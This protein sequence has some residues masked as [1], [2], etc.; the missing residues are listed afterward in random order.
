MTLSLSAIALWPRLS[1]RSLHIVFGC[2][3]VALAVAAP[4]RAVAEHAV[5]L[6]GAPK[7]PASFQHFDYVNPAAPS[8]GALTLSVVSENSSFDKFNPFSLRGK[9]APGLSELV[10]ETL[11]VLS[12]DE[13]NTQYGLLADDIRV[14]ADFGSVEFHLHPGARFSDGQPVTAE[15]V[16][17]SFDVLTSKLASPRFRA[18]FDEVSR[19]IVL[20]AST[21]RFEFERKGRD[22]PFIAGSLPV[23]SRRWGVV[24]GRA[25]VPFDQ[26]RLE[27]PLA[28]GPYVIERGSSGQDVVYRRNPRYWGALIPSRR[29]MFNFERVIYKLYKDA[30]TQVAALRAGE[31]D[32]FNETRMRYWCCQFIGKRF[33]S[34]ELVKEI[35]PHENPPAM[36]GWVANLREE[37]FQD[38]RVREALNYAHDFEWINDKIFAGEFERVTSYFSGTELA[39]HGS[40]SAEER[41]LLERYRGEIPDAAF[42]P[43]FVQPSTRPPGGLR[44]NLTHALELLGQAGWHNRDGV[45]RNASGEPF[46]IEVVGGR[47]QAPYLDAYYLNI[48]KLGIVIRKRV[49]DTATNRQNLSNFDFDFASLALREARM[50]GAE[51]WRTFNSQDADVSGSEN[52]AGVKSRAID[53][54][55]EKLLDANTEE[56]LVLTARVLDRVLTHSHFIV[57]WRYLTKHYLIYNRR[58]ARPPQQPRFFGAYEWALS[59]WWNGPEL[60]PAHRPVAVVA[61]SKPAPLGA[62]SALVLALAGVSVWLLR[63]RRSA[64]RTQPPPRSAA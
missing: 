60:S 5:A 34:G 49:S 57:P 15:D 39:A 32:L 51:L 8:G 53:E 47:K 27:P 37:R 6:F 11:T 12:L 1:A 55:I 22:L 28:S 62:A 29:G 43:M 16:K 61:A 35:V 18:Y 46:E 33:D 45:L 20:N 36:N 59:T 3:A 19:V 52:V 2:A 56:E 9:P 64:G 50:P 17:H 26:L 31:F 54:L 44:K 7:Y 21:V 48:A 4:S 14:A 30:D 40:P 41:A 38:P 23:F 63:A 58:L 10:F 24:S 25:A 42:G 13:Q